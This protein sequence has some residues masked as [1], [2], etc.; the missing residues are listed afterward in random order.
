MKSFSEA[1]FPST[2][3]ILMLFP[4]RIFGLLDR[5]HTYKGTGRAFVL[6]FQGE[7]SPLE[8]GMNIVWKQIPGLG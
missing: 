7:A 8:N 3:M 1:A 6:N 4:P 2:L 5:D